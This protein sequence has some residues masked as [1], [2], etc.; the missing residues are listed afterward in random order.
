MRDVVTE[1][2]VSRFFWLPR[3]GGA[4]RR[5]RA[6]NDE[7]SKLRIYYGKGR[8]FIRISRHA[9]GLLSQRRCL[10]SLCSLLIRRCLNPIAVPNSNISGY[11]FVDH[12][13]PISPTS[14]RTLI[15]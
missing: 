1:V 9:A 12:M 4:S 13:G 11:I 5:V 2:R 6:L 8:I 7:A 10:T 14:K 15:L 3:S